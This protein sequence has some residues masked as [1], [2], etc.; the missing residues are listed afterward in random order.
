MWRLG[1]FA[2]VAQIALLL[3][4]IHATVMAQGFQTLAPYAFLMDT[5]T[6]SVL[7][8]KSADELMD[9][10]STTKIMTAEVVFEEIAAG[11]LKLTDEFTISERAWREGGARSGGSTMFAKLNSR[12]SVSDLLQGLLVQSGNDAAIA[13]AEG[14]SGSEE[15]FATLMNERAAKLGLTH[16]H[17]MNA[18]GAPDPQHKVTAREMALLAEHIIRTYP[19]LY[20][21]FGEREFTWNKIRQP[22]RNPLLAMNIGADGVKTGDTKVSGY[23][24]VGSAVQNGQRLIVVVNGL[25]TARERGEEARKLLEWGFRSFQQKLLFNAG[26]IIGTADVFGGASGSVGLVAAG[27]VKLLVARGNDDHLSAKVS[28]TGPIVAP[29]TKGAQIADLIVTDGDKTLA[30]IP[31]MAAQDVGK[32][33]LQQRALDALYEFSAQM[34]Q[35]YVLKRLH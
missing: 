23:G 2:G 26:T 25:K 9:P 17:F 7:F 19:D 8:E 29:I 20:K 35:K 4:S 11:R 22:N 21:I 15:A 28:Y 6:N 5:D 14:I 34:M 18:W 10:A 27:P 12:V 31:L 16:L 13:L 24:L 3:F 30:K 32:G 1:G 33:T